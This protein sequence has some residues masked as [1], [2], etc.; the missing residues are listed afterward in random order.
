MILLI[1]SYDSFTNNL[2]HLIATNSNQQVAT[3]HNDAFPPCEYEKFYTEYL[4]LFEYVVIGPGPGHPSIE[5]DVGIISWLLQRMKSA[6]ESGD[7]V[8]P[9]LGICLGFQSLCYEFGNPVDKL[10]NVRHGQIYDIHPVE[11][12]AGLF[13]GNVFES[14][15]YHS[16]FVGKVNEEIVP[17]AYCF[18]PE[19][20]EKILMAMK[21]RSL[22]FY[23]VQYHP[24]SI[25]SKRGDDLVKNF[26]KIATEYNR[27]HRPDVFDKH[28]DLSSN[29]LNHH[30]VHEEYLIEGGDLKSNK[31]DRIYFKQIK[32]DVNAMDVC[33]YFHNR[34]NEN[35]FVLLNSASIP[36]EWSIIGLPIEGQSEVIT[37]SVDDNKVHISAYK[38][39]SQNN[40]ITDETVWKVIAK[41]MQEKFVSRDTI[42][43]TLGGVQGRALPFLGGYMG[44]ISY[45][46]GQHLIIE[47]L[48]SICGE[49]P[50]PDLK[51]IF[52]ERFLAYDHINQ[53]WYI[54]SINKQ[55][56]TKWGDSIAEELTRV[57]PINIDNIPMT[58]KFLAEDTDQDMIKFK[59]PDQDIYAQ[60]FAKCQ[61][62]LHSGDSYELCL[63]TQSKIQLP[64]YIDPWDIYKVLTLRKNP[65]P[66][67][68]FMQFDDCVLLSSSPERFLS[69]KDDEKSQ[70]KMAELRP[71]KGTVKNTDD[72]TH[73]MASAILKT[74][75]EMGEN[76]MIVDLI[77][78][79]LFQF[80]SSV[81]V[82]QLMTVEEY[83]TVFQLVSVI[84]GSLDRQ[85]YHGIDLLHSSLPPGSMTGAP[86]RR[87]VELLQDIESMQEGIVGGRRGIYSGVVG[88]WSVT[89][90]ADWSVIIRSVFHYVDDVNNRDNTKCW[91]IGAGGAITVLSDAQGEWEEMDVK[92]RS[93]LSAFVDDV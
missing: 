2:A 38:S 66:F 52:I 73:E 81:Q 61:E 76:L 88:Y 24:E 33:D 79:D 59:F 71:I 70:A 78:H 9:V 51:L 15:R 29:W 57:T 77:R 5:K 20:D 47:K 25:C 4:P 39:A 10:K 84:Q 27:N 68:C 35:D 13:D 87:S 85:G 62:W 7:T 56:D 34:D 67:S 16:L 44:L 14:V 18:E 82:T 89:D 75:K 60:Q 6:S 86:K 53:D 55:D 46:E 12:S 50:T 22:P 41:R 43:S 8:V 54:V 40:T 83:K 80:L 42:N 91:R 69:W 65:S 11:D 3:I 23:G 19:Q 30:A 64:S 1:D 32:L 90:D 21:H 93:A 28:V 92:L 31:L 63:T 74:P 72:V 26:T 49:N 58:V 45:E 48:E 36:G 37:H 17:L